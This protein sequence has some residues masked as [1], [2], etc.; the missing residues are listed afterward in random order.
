MGR[1]GDADF[2]EMPE[3]GPHE[4]SVEILEERCG[5]WPVSETSSEVRVIMAEHVKRTMWAKQGDGLLSE[6]CCFG[7]LLWC[8]RGMIPDPD[9]PWWDANPGFYLM[10]WDDAIPRPSNFEVWHDGVLALSVT[11]SAT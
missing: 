6:A 3:E 4:L 5:P 8:P 2:M 9:E 10:F 11:L 7:Q 1:W